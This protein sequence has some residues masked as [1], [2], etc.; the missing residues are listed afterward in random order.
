ME[1]H[2][3]KLLDSVARLRSSEVW[4]VVLLEVLVIVL[5]DHGLLLVVLWHRL[6]VLNILLHHVLVLHALVL[7]A[8]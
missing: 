4:T 1:R 5:V 6:E 3:L 7:G 2:L 8:R